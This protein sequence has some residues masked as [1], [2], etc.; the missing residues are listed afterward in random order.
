M[1][2][3]SS[4]RCTHFSHIAAVCVYSDHGTGRAGPHQESV[5]RSS[6]LLTA[7]E[8]QHLPGGWRPQWDVSYRGRIV[9]GTYRTG[10]VSYQGRVVLGM[11]HTRWYDHE[12]RACLIYHNR[13]N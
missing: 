13:P 1:L 5:R 9:P 7:V 12:Y 2:F 8:A 6:L 11:Y 3:F 4:S 10:D